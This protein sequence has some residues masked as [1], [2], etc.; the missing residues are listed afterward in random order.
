MQGAGFLRRYCWTCC[1]RQGNPGF[2]GRTAEVTAGLGVR[3]GVS[4][5]PVRG[6]PP[7]PSLPARSLLEEKSAEPGKRKMIPQSPA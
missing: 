6:P 1:V 3:V 5:F 7:S 4:R 2:L